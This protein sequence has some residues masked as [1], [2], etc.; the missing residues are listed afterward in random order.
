MSSFGAEPPFGGSTYLPSTFLNTPFISQTGTVSPNPFTGILGPKPGTPQDW[1]S[2]RPML[3]CGDFQPHMPDAILR[4]YNFFGKR[5]SPKDMVLQLGYVGSQG[6]RLL[7]TFGGH[8][9]PR[10][11][12]LA[13]TSWRLRTTTR[14]ETV[15]W[16][17]PATLQRQIKTVCCKEDNQ[18]AVCVTSCNGSVLPNGFHLP[19]G[20]TVATAG[21]TLKAVAVLGCSLN[22]ELQSDDGHRMSSRRRSRLH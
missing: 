4:Q 17:S 20:G 22:A 7:T 3:L 10:I 11:L 16:W 21:Q 6:H 18:F 8:P 15:C 5:A 1:A 2:F 12:K 13:W 9:M 19:T 14:R